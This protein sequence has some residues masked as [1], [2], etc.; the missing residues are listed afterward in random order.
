MPNY[1]VLVCGITVGILFAVIVGVDL[2]TSTG[3]P[4]DSGQWSIVPAVAALGFLVGGMIGCV[5]GNLWGRKGFSGAVGFTLVVA[6]CG[7]AGLAVAGFLGAETRITVTEHSRETEYGAP[8]PVLIAG[9]IV[10]LMIGAVVAWR[11]GRFRSVAVA[12]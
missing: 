9:A 12:S 10:G 8:R 7:F 6:V 11:F 5:I 1:R 3:N 4:S 2:S